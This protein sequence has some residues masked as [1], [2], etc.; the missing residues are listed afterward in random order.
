MWTWGTSAILTRKPQLRWHGTERQA[1]LG[2]AHQHKVKGGE[3]KETRYPTLTSLGRSYSVSVTMKDAAK[4][5]FLSSRLKAIVFERLKVLQNQRNSHLLEH[6]FKQ[7][8]KQNGVLKRKIFVKIFSSF[9]ASLQDSLAQK[10]PPE[11]CG[12][13]FQMRPTEQQWLSHWWWNRTRPWLHAPPQP[14]G[15]P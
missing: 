5:P 1:S 10:P 11:P 13:C 2:Q 15:E 3:Q 7:T 9:L 14:K 8:N 4:N 6:G 12:P